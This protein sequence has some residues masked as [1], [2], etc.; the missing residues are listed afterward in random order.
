MKIEIHVDFYHSSGIGT[1]RVYIWGEIWRGSPGV[2]HQ[3]NNPSIK[4]GFPQNNTNWK[5]MS[6]LVNKQYLS[7]MLWGSELYSRICQ[8]S[9]NE[10]F[11]KIVNSLPCVFQVETTWKQSFPCR[12]KV[13]YM[14]QAI[15]YFHK[16]LYLKMFDRVLNKPTLFSSKRSKQFRNVKKSYKNFQGSLFGPAGAVENKKF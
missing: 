2:K 16:I 15:K 13:E 9:E 5:S 4:I 6:V 10:H 11:G 7:K 8:A 14:W 1:K 12:F 3:I